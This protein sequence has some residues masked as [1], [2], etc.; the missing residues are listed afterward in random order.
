MSDPNSAADAEIQ[1]EA[2]RWLA[3]V[4]ED[5]D[6]AEAAA[7][8]RWRQRLLVLRDQFLQGASIFDRHHFAEFRPISV[9]IVEDRLRPR[10]ACIFRM[11]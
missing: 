4:E 8:P 5:I 6:V 10:R 3:I 9:P 7:S 1:A 2:G 11:I